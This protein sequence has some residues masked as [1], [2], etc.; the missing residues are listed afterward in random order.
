MITAS[1][2]FSSI[3]PARLSGFPQVGLAIFLLLFTGSCATID[4]VTETDALPAGPEARFTRAE[5]PTFYREAVSYDGMVVSAHPLGSRAGVKMLEKGGNAVDAAVATAFAIAVLEPNMSGLGGSGAMTIW[6][7]EQQRSDYLD[8]YAQL[9]ADPDYAIETDPDSLRTSERRVAVPGMVAGLLEALDRYGSLDRQT[10]MEPAI[11]LAE[12]GFVIHHL[13]ANVIES[14]HRRLTGDPEAAELFYPDGTPLR[15]GERLVQNDLARVL[16]RIA[17]EGRE[18]FYSG[19]TA[20]RALEKLARGNSV[21]T[22]DD[23]ENY[24]PVWRGALC[25]EWNGHRILTAPPSLA[26]HEVILALKLAERGGIASLGHPLASGEAL[27]VMVDA[28]R[29]ARADRGYWNGDPS[30]VGLP[31]AGIIS[32]PYASLRS[33]L[34]GQEVPDTLKP[35]DPWTATWQYTAP[36]SCTGPGFFRLPLDARPQDDGQLRSH[37]PAPPADTNDEPVTDPDDEPE[38]TTHISVVDRHGNAVSMT[39]TLGLYFGSSVIS[40]GVFYNSA[41]TNFGGD[42]GSIRGPNRTARSSTAP[43]IVLDED[44]VALVVGSPGSARIPPA[45]VNMVIHTLVHDIHPADAIRMPR[46]YPMTDSRRVQLER[47][48]APEALE[49]LHQRGYIIDPVN[50]PMNMLFGGVQMIRVMEDGLMIGV[51]DPR[52]DGAPEGLEMHRME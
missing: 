40:E 12:E 25:E 2:I 26:G 5:A 10:V 3:Y 38:N 15:A 42:Y 16:R 20:E 9:G 4:P 35:G 6:N 52:R 50:F 27:N 1:S 30:H 17:D 31:V 11:R 36:S 46:I 41:A 32:D 14:Y 22:L 44:R 21:L 48:F 28:I 39:N 37:I 51:S 33:V 49:I 45:I 29:I 18:G 23:F 8:F 47:G 19:K 24:A 34:I 43:T 13:L 7:R